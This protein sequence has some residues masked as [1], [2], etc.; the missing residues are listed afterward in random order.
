MGIFDRFK[1]GALTSPVVTPGVSAFVEVKADPNSA[2]RGALLS[3]YSEMADYD[4]IQMAEELY[5]SVVLYRCVTQIAHSMSTLSFYVKR[6]RGRSNDTEDRRVERLLRRPNA[7]WS[8]QSW[9]YFLSAN[10]LLSGNAYSAGVRGIGGRVLEIWPV[11]YRNIETHR[12]RRGMNVGKYTYKYGGM[13]VDYP[14]DQTTGRSDM[15]HWW[16]PNLTDDDKLFGRGPAPVTSSNVGIMSVLE[17]RINDFLS[18]NS[19]MSGILSPSPGE[20]LTD[21]EWESLIEALSQFRIGNRRSGQ[22]AAFSK[23]GL[24]FEKISLDIMDLISPEAKSSIA[25]DICMPFGIPPMLIGLPGDNTYA[26]MGEARRAFWLDVLIPWYGMPL[27]NSL[28]HFMYPDDVNAEIVVDVDAIDAVKEYRT[29]FYQSVAVADFLTVDEK[30]A[31]CGFDP[32]GAERGG[33]LITSVERAEVIRANAEALGKP[34]KRT[35]GG[36]KKPNN[37]QGAGKA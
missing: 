6:D 27:A 3:G 17:G 15:M 13:E 35:E 14:V 19:F 20:A 18:N 11:H 31:M 21:K 1:R 5:K 26:N 28:T 37:N 34:V 23:G 16:I 4:A 24:K 33:N 22:I 7:M 9:L 8:G 10:Y 29:N 25:R 12:S 36:I 2:A 30:R 32:V